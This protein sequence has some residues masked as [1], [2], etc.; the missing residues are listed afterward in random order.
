MGDCLACTGHSCPS[1]GAQLPPFVRT[2]SLCVA[3]NEQIAQWKSQAADLQRLKFGQL[4]EL[5]S[6][7]KMASSAVR[8]SQLRQWRQQHPRV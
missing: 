5:D 7:D 6:L 8:S 2:A 1:Y 4:I 3:C